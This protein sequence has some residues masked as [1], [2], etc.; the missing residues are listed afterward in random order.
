MSVGFIH[1]GFISFDWPLRELE[2]LIKITDK[3]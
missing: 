1:L 2:K 3:N